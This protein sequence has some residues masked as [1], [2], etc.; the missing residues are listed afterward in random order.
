MKLQSGQS[1]ILESIQLDQNLTER[2][3]IQATPHRQI[4]ELISA[5]QSMKLLAWLFWQCV[6]I[7]MSFLI[8]YFRENY[9]LGEVGD[10]IPS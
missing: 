7:Q 10:L 1:T 3:S 2:L 9:R 5:Q 4:R 6:M 8:L